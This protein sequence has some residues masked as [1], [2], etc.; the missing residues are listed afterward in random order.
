LIAVPAGAVEEGNIVVRISMAVV[1]SIQT[2]IAED[3]VRKRPK[4]AARVYVFHQDP[5]AAL[6]QPV[7]KDMYVSSRPVEEKHAVYRG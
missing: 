4:P 5:Y 1:R 3:V 2:A 7:N 6:R